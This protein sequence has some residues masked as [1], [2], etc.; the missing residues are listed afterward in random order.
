M[1]Q[2]SGPELLP[3]ANICLRELVCVYKNT[4]PAD[5]FT[6]FQNL[7]DKMEYANAWEN[8]HCKITNTQIITKK[9]IVD[10]PKNIISDKSLPHA[11]SALAILL[12]SGYKVQSHAVHHNFDF[13]KNYLSARQ[14]H[15]DAHDWLED[16]NKGFFNSVSLPLINAYFKANPKCIHMDINKEKSKLQNFFW[17]NYIIK[18]GLEIDTYINQAEAN[19]DQLTQLHIIKDSSYYKELLRP[20]RQSPTKIAAT[21]KEIQDFLTS[22]QA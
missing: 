16:L 13:F 22:F 5:S 17:K 14:L 12:L 1:D 11:F 7:M 6:F 9:N 20:F 19:L 8:I 15:D 4:L 3:V 18:I 21:K 10:Y 2:D